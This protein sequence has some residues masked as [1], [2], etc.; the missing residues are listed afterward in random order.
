MAYEALLI[1]AIAPGLSV[2]LTAATGTNLRVLADVSPASGTVGAIDWLRGGSR[3]TEATVSSNSASSQSLQVVEATEVTVIGA[4]TG[5]VTISATNTITRATAGF[6]ADRWEIGQRCALLAAG[7]AALLPD[8]GKVL[9]ITAVTDTAITVSGAA[10]TNGAVPAGSRLVRLTGDYVKSIPAQC[11]TSPTVPNASLLG[12]QSVDSSIDKT[13]N[14]LG[15]K[16]LLLVGV[17]A[18][19]SGGDR[20]EVRAKQ[21]LM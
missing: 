2:T 12:D 5:A 17:T 1:S 4:A 13:G 19:L 15:A 9:T 3:I 7:N 18:A 8:E 6:L 14:S 21:G 11:G 16:T 10:L 20:I